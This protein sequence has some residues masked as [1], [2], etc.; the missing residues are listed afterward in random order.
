M[1]KP[2]LSVGQHS[3]PEL[4]KSARKR[5]VGKESENLYC[6][7]FNN[8][9]DGFV[10]VEPIFDEA[11]NSDDY[12]MLE[13][14]DAWEQ[15]TGLRASDLV[16]KRIR[17]AL[18]NVE[19]VWP[20]AF[21]EVARMG[22]AK[23]FESYNAESARWYDLHVFPYRKGQVG[24]MFRDITE[25]KQAEQLLR[26][27]ES[28]LQVIA[29]ATPV[30]LNR[31][32]RDLK[33]V[34]VN[35]ACADMFGLPLAEIIGKPVVD[36]IGN[37]AFETIRPHIEKV[38]R[39]EKVLYEAEIPYKGAGTRSM[40][41]EYIPEKD[42]NGEVVGWLATI[43][44]ITQR[45]QAE[46]ALRE[47]ERNLAEANQ[48]KEDIL[49][50]ISD[51]FYALDK[52]L[53]FTYVN[54]A[55]ED[56]WASSRA[57]LIG[58]K[59]D[60]VFAGQID[61]SISKFHQVLEEQISQNYQVYSKVIQRWGEM[62]V[63]PSKDGISVYFHDIT[64]R[65]WAEEAL[66]ESEQLYRT[67][68]ENTEDAF[69]LVEPMYNESGKVFDFK[70]LRVNDAFKTQSG[71]IADV[72]SKTVRQVL[73][74]VEPYWFDQYDEVMKTNKSMR[75]QEFNKDTNRWYDMFYFPHG[76]NQVGVLFRDITRL[77]EAEGMLG[78]RTAQISNTNDILLAEIDERKMTEFKLRAAVKNLRAMA[79]EVVMAEERS[80]KHIAA[81]LHDT[82][83]QT[84][85]AAKLRSQLIQNNIPKKSKPI[86]NE[87]QELVSEGI[88]QSRAIMSELSPPVLNEL[89]LIHALEWLTEQ[90]TK[91]HN[92]EIN[93]E[94]RSGELPLPRDI[95]ILLFQATRE[96][97]MN[98]VKHAQARSATVKF[99]SFNDHMIN[100]EIRDDGKGFDMKKTFKPDSEGGYGIYGIRERLQHFGGQLAIKSKPGKGTTVLILCPREIE[101]KTP[102]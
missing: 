28:E 91:K 85:A 65:K 64:E 6:T 24:V 23:H 12:R 102:E 34:Y 62:N 94:S 33:Y 21:A 82:V 40:L 16:G 56:I 46:E 39:G 44:D 66:K 97:L 51:C 87:L 49:E 86:F 37:E 2:D 72:V 25:R 48:Q 26:E 83:V 58:R 88:I 38:L 35:N 80:R 73:P 11:G 79:S 76:S 54:K 43:L 13:A 8:T 96:L 95:Q 9:G 69:Q 99:S 81:D 59:I 31:L 5:A 101:T 53:R 3:P 61:T 14:N 78:D 22:T 42:R 1:K 71:I 63:Y 98:I 18:P 68:F 52:D 47:S 100:I 57:D 70:F 15:Q 77:K 93:F 19:H 50:S 60:E 29:N 55:A 36:I 10:L 20:A 7:L 92:L 30:I 17:E 75:S 4:R 41:V 27:K 84:L 90:I 67:L 32:S 89:G 74:E 45:K